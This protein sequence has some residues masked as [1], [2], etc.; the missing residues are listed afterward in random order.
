MPSCNGSIVTVISTVIFTCCITAEINIKLDTYLLGS[1]PQNVRTDDT[2][3]KWNS[4]KFCVILFA[5][6]LLC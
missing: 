1:L 6:F 4:A 5:S 3:N 2:Y